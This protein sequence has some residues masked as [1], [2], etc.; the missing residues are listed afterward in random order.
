MCTAAM[1]ILE[2]HLR[3]NL[4]HGDNLPSYVKFPVDYLSITGSLSFRCVAFNASQK[5]LRVE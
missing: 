5:A 4:S 2:S 3:L 1:F